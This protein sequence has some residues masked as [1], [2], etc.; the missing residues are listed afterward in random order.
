MSQ[1]DAN[2]D[3]ADAQYAG[4]SAFA[5]NLNENDVGQGWA[6]DSIEYLCKAAEKSQSD[7]KYFGIFFS[8]D[9]RRDQD[10]ADKFKPLLNQYMGRGC[11]YKYD[12][13]YFLST[14]NGGWTTNTYWSRFFQS[15]NKKR[16][17]VYFVPDFDD[18]TGYYASDANWWNYWAKTVD[19]LF[20]W[21][22]A[23]PAAAGEVEVARDNKVLAAAVDHQKSYMVGLSSLQYKHWSNNEGQREHRYRRGLDTLPRRMEQILG[24]PTKAEFAQTLTWNDA[25]ESHY[26]GT[27]HKQGVGAFWGYANNEEYRHTAWQPL[28]KSFNTAFKAGAAASGMRPVNGDAVTGALWHRGFLRSSSCSADPWGRPSNWAWTRD[29]VNWAIVMPAD[30]AGAR[31]QVYSGGRQIASRALRPGLNY[32]SEEGMVAGAQYVEV[33][34][35]VNGGTQQIFSKTSHVQVTANPKDNI[36]NYN[37]VVDNLLPGGPN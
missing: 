17:E 28:V 2:L 7:G 32:G 33:V 15:L 13:K 14:F 8:M 29:T 26:I 35:D 4:F 30:A 24:M 36:C 3:V 16:N 11:H 21:E 23:W 5:I 12:G 37:Y 25:G 1:S 22:T 9:I 10:N 18:T 34:R 6:K 27:L 31:V 19:G 20:T